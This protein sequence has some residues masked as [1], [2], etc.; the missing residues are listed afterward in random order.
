MPSP[1]LDD[2]PVMDTYTTSM[3]NAYRYIQKGCTEQG[4]IP[5]SEIHS[6]YKMFKKDMCETK[7]DF[8]LLIDQMNLPLME[9]IEEEKEKA[10][11][12]GK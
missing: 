9:L 7:R 8:I 10:K 2:R 1:A 4:T 6:Y 11:A 5:V 12:K 3:V